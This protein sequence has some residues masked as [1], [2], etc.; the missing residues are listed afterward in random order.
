MTEL[1]PFYPPVLKIHKKQGAGDLV[2]WSELERMEA[3]E[4]T[5]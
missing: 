2:F 3:E 5:G 1:I 4:T